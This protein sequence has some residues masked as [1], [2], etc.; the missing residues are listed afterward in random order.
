MQPD[1]DSLPSIVFDR[2]KQ[3]YQRVEPLDH[4]D[5]DDLQGDEDSLTG[6]LAKTIRRELSGS[7]G[8]VHW[9]TRVKKLRGRGPGAPEKQLGA[10]LLLRLRSKTRRATLYGVRVFLANRKTLGWR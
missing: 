6:A 8:H 1:L 3:K 9:S 7:H 5:F 10:D 2:L 4:D